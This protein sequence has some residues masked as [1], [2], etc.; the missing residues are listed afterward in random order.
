MIRPQ[1]AAEMLR[2]SVVATACLMLTAASALAATPAF[3]VHKNGTNQTVAQNT[4]VKLTWSAE[5][6]DT[7]TN[8]VSDRFTPTV[9]GKY[10]IVLSAQCAQAGA[11]MPSI[12][13]NGVL[14][15][16]S[17]ITDFNI[18]QTA[19][20]SA[21]LDMNGSSD[22]VEAFINSSSNVII[23]TATQTYFSGMQL[24]GGGS[25][26]GGLTALTGD[27]TASGSGS[28]AASIASNA[29]TTTKLGPGSVTN[30]KLANMAAETVKGND[31]A[32]AFAPVDLNMTQLRGMLGSGAP[33]SG[34]FLRGDGTW[35]AV[36]SSADNLGNHMATTT[37][38]MGAQAI[39]S[40]AGTIRDANG[41]WVRT[42]GNTGWY[43]GTHGGGWYMT[44]ATYIRN[45]GS[46][47]V[48]LNANITAPAFLYS[49]DRRLKSDIRPITGA[50]NKLAAIDGVTFNFSNDH[51]RSE[52]LGVIAQDVEAV[53]PQAVARGE[54]G[55]LAVDY[56]SLVPVLIEAIKELRS[57]N[58]NLR[59]ELEEISRTVGGGQ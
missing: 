58:D 38:D 2:L 35:A 10:L 24:D 52:H 54:D 17:A 55:Y 49:S 34:N 50:L 32:V 20:A 48:I 9:A 41:G 15:A 42:Y 59:A 4:D 3:S 29:V 16:R 43:S 30:A 12:Y 19:Q 57:D 26:G 40:S 7:N 44:D 39:T 46:K 36:P 33:G 23:G 45:Y 25:G 6:F 21:I 22:F 27:V 28:V 56:P 51:E 14:V 13:M 37:L 53:L 47:Q 8:F 1:P 11:C 18:G 31:A 5:G